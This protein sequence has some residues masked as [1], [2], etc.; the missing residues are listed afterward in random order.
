MNVPHENVRSQ[1]CASVAFTDPNHCAGVERTAADGDGVADGEE[2]TG[3]PG[4][5]PRRGAPGHARGEVT[6]PAISHP[7]GPAGD[8]PASSAAPEG[9][10]PPPPRVKPP[11]LRVVASRV[12]ALTVAYSVP[13]AYERVARCLPASA[14]GSAQRR[15]AAR[16]GA[17]DLEVRATRST[18][19]LA[20]EN[21]ELRGIVLDR[22][23]GGWSVELTAAAVLLAT[24]GFEGALARL[25]ATATALGWRQT[26]ELDERGQR[27]DC[28]LRRGDLAVDVAGWQVGD[29]R[30]AGAPLGE[31]VLSRAS[32]GEFSPD[33]DEKIEAASR[34]A[35]RTYRSHRQ[36]TGITVGAGG[37]IVGRIYDKL[38]EL[39][40]ESTAPEKRAI[41]ESIWSAAGWT[42][43]EPVTRVE[44]QLRGE[45]LDEL[46]LRDPDAVVPRLDE[47]WSYL[48]GGGD[49]SA[50]AAPGQRRTAWLR[51]VAPHSATRLARCR[52]LDAWLVVQEHVFHHVAAPAQRSR[53]RRGGASEAQV[54]GS[55]LSMLAALGQLESFESIE[56]DAIDSID[57]QR[58]E[59]LLRRRLRDDLVRA[60]DPLTKDLIARKQGAVQAFRA[61]YGSRDAASARFWRHDDVAAAAAAA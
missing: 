59:A 50:P 12:D 52:V 55:V 40:R 41:E 58:A 29:E 31:C 13:L 48:T 1:G 49:R 32:V 20:V 15:V 14:P 38:A 21:G 43:G 36:I 25:H 37:A 33:D 30:D 47:L 19:Q 44:F 8:R 35:T 9:P 34:T 60:V 39:N 45:A 54:I 61:Y 3:G 5:G 26:G 24:R 10:P 46:G 16:F 23:Q 51:L 42:R 7:E 18:G 4:P 6:P 28:R 27:T 56:S 57:T 11:G 22:A 53:L 2:R 17:V